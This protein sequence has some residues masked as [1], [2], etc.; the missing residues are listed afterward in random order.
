[1]KLNLKATDESIC[2]ATIYSVY[3]TS[4]ETIKEA[5]GSISYREKEKLIKQIPVKKWFKKEAITSV[6]EYVTTKNTIAKKRSVIYD[7]YTGKY[8]ATYYAPDELFAAINKKNLEINNTK[9]GY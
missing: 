8:F 4:Y 1:M 6:E 9:V 7:K 3:K 5:D 2:I